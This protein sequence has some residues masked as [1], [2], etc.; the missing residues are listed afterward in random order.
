MNRSNKFLIG[1]I[2]VILT[3]TLLFSHETEEMHMHEVV[4]CTNDITIRS[5]TLTFCHTDSAQ[6]TMNGIHLYNLRAE[7]FFEGELCT[8]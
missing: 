3:I 6:V 4:D 7:R 2:A 8:K 5:H 1:S